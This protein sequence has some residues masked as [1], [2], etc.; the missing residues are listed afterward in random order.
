MTLCK[1]M[2]T[3]FK[4]IQ[5]IHLQNKQKNGIIKLNSSFKQISLEETP[6]QYRMEGDEDEPPS[7]YD[8][9]KYT[10]MERLLIE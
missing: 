8:T 10:I 6:Q 2:M 4:N 7:R 9:L 5:L 3:E 1:G